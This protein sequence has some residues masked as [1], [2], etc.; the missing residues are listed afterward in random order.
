VT[1]LKARIGDWLAAAYAL[2][3]PLRPTPGCRVLMYHAIGGKVA[4][5]AQGLYS[6]APE[7]FARHVRMLAGGSTVVAL[8][9]GVAAGYGLAITFD[10][11]YRDNLTVAAPLLVEAALPFT[12]FVTPAFIDS[13][14][15]Q[16]LTRADVKTLADMPGITIGAHGFSH[17]RLTACDDAALAGELKNSRT[18]LEDLL[19]RPVHTM[20]YPHGAVDGRVRAAAAAAGFTI[21]AGSRFGSL[22]QGNDPLVVPRTDIW[23]GDDVGRLSAKIAGH[24]DWMAWR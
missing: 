9:R 15:P 16:Y 4:G 14:E 23:A 13:G 18:W 21:A 7:L 20:S 1:P 10:D 24:W 6:L 2:A 8:E 5:D 19:G 11:G 12:V 17:C 22:R 3:A